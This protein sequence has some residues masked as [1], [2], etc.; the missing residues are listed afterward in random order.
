MFVWMVFFCLIYSL[1]LVG[2]KML[3]QS[4]FFCSLKYKNIFSFLFVIFDFIVLR[5][6]ANGTNA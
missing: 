3:P 6:N 2:F 1:I 5:E 4:T